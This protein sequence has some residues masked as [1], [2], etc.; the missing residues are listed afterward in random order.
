MDNIVVSCHNCGKKNRIPADKQH[1]RPK[2]GSCGRSIDMG[3]AAVPVKL[4]DSSLAP[5]I[6]QTSLPVLV[7]FFSPACGPCRMMAPIIDNLAKKFLGRVI[8]AK[9]D[10][11]RNSMAPAHYRIRGVPTLIV[12]KDGQAVDQMTGAMP[13]ETLSQR[14]NRFT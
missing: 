1:M 3:S 11:S 9:L 13:E 10:T 4:D 5:F 6:S 8:I 2:C 7:D 14:L 12:F